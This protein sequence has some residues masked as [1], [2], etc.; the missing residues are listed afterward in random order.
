MNVS[1]VVDTPLSVTTLWSGPKG[2]TSTVSIATQ[3]PSTNMYQGSLIIN[4]L[5]LERDNGSVYTC[6][7]DLVSTNDPEHILSNSNS[8]GLTIIIDGETLMI[9]NFT[10]F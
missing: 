10:T 7:A 5:M 8:N 3:V 9:I 4:E 2:F 6:T 1:A